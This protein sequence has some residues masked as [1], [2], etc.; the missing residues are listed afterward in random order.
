MVIPA[1]MTAQTAKTRQW[2]GAPFKLSTTTAIGDVN[3]DGDVNVTDVTLLVGHILGNENSNFIIEN[4]DVNGDGDITV[5]DVTKLV[6]NILEGSQDSNA[7]LLSTTQLSLS[8]GIEGYCSSKQA[9]VEILSGSGN[10][11]VTS[12]NTAV[13]TAEIISGQANN[14]QGN[15]FAGAKKEVRHTVILVTAQGEGKAILTLID[16]SY[17]NT[18]KIQVT[19]GPYYL[20]C[21]DNNHP[22]IIDL[23]LPS[24]TR[25]A[26][27]NVGATAPED[28]G[29]YYAW[30]ETEEK[31]YYDSS[32]YQYYQNGSYVNLGSDIAGTQYDVARVKWGGSWVMPTHDQQMELCDNCTYE[33]TT[34]NGVKGGKFTSKTNGG[35]IFLPAAGRRLTSGLDDAGSQGYYWSSMQGPSITG[36]TFC[37][38]FGSGYTDWSYANRSSG[39]SVRTV[40]RN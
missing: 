38:Y 16:N 4:A 10:Y 20:S 13:A 3:G 11:S 37:L 12:S 5:T 14:K 6:S 31:N 40:V 2:K 15:N 36:S 8:S 32:T 24:G 28:C 7:I 25:W 18:S 33:W 19:V 23:G 29:G 17:Y 21:P 22:H 26:C 27:C 30:G 9:T 39:L 1:A 34:V 35:I